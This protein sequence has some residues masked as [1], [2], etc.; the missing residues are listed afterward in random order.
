MS[1]IGEG[2]VGSVM[3][4]SSGLR[5][6]FREPSLVAVDHSSARVQAQFKI[7]GTVVPWGRKLN[8]T[9]IRFLVM[10]PYFRGGTNPIL[11]LVQISVAEIV[12]GGA[13]DRKIY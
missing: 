3:L 1:L 13:N 7:H 9:E 6:E 4:P 5:F 11:C 2:C 10:G 12:N 8:S